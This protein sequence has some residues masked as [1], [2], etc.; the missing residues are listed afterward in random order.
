MAVVERR[1]CD[2]DVVK[3]LRCWLRAGIFEG[4]VVSE[5][6]AGTPQGSPISPLLA[7]IV[8][9]TLDEAWHTVGRRPGTLVRYADDLVAVCP[10]RGRAEQARD[11]V[12]AVLAPLGLR[13]HP[14][15][16]RIV[17]LH[18]GAEGFDF[19][20]FHLRK[21]ESWRRRGKWWLLRWPSQRAMAAIRAKVR[22]RTARYHAH[23]S[24]RQVVEDLNR[25]L[26][27][28]GNY[29]R[30]GNSSRQFTAV[31]SYVRMSLAKFASV[32]HGRAGRNWTTTY[33][34][35][36]SQRLG[37]AWLVGTVRSRAVHARR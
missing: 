32:K 36:W 3:L 22:Q 26:R 5:T 19:L 28:W 9:H 25:V 6:E 33:N 35:A 31:D 24:L 2:R 27:G 1:V 34:Y 21:C 10:T 12:A 15:K 16:T 23:L 7:N 18:K 8:L 13:M 29:F 14:D 37:V 20:G 30:Y 11:L 17:H 4:G